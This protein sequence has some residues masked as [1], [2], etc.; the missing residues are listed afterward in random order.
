MTPIIPEPELDTLANGLSQAGYSILDQAL[1]TALV[2]ALR[3]N[4]QTMN[5]ANYQP[6]HIGRDQRHHNT[7]VRQDAICWLSPHHPPDH[8]YLQVME[9]LRYE[10]NRRLFLGLFDY[11]SHYAHYAPGASYQKHRDVF[12]QPPVTRIVTTLLY[13]NPDWPVDAGGELR[14]YALDGETMLEQIAPLEG[15]LVLFLSAP[16]PHEVLP[17]HRD[18]YS[19]AGWFRSH[20]P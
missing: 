15:R 7:T 20:A 9:Q 16:F 10:L 18:R 6:A 1:P 4:A 17:A 12:A 19:I 3:I 2:T 13:L 11:E 8:T 5:P 14:L